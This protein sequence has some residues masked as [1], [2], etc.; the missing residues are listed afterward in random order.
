MRTRDALAAVGGKQAPQG[1]AVRAT[2]AVTG[3]LATRTSR[4]G[5]LVR[6]GV[7]GSALAADPTGFL[8]TP[9]T[10]YASVCGPGSSCSTGWTAF[11]A[12][13]NHGINACPPGS[14]A[15]GWWKS[16]GASLCGGRAR[17]IVDCNATCTCST[18]SGRAGICSPSCW[19]CRCTCGPAG[20]CDQRRVCCNGFRYG[21]CNQQVRQVG[22]VQCRVVSCTPPWK[23]ERCSTSPATD[24]ATRDHNAP[25]LPGAWTALTAHYVALGEHGSELGATI[26]REVAV[27]GGRA[28]RYQHGRMSWS[29]GHG[30]R[31][32]AGAI[33][34]RFGLL[35]AEA[36]LLGFPVAD[37][38]RLGTG[39]ASR[40]QR[41]DIFWHPTTGAHE[42]TGPIL[43]RY[44]QAGRATGALGYPTAGPV[45]PHDG[46]GRAAAF[47]HGR[48]SWHPSLGPARLLGPDLARRY[49]AL[50]AES[51]PLGYPLADETALPAGRFVTLQGGRISW[52][53]T[54]GAWEVRDVLAQAYLG[55]GAETGPLGFPV[56]AEEA[57]AGGRVS[58]FQTGRVAASAATGA[59]WSRGPITERHI[60]LGAEQGQLGFPT[61]D[62]YAPGPGTRRNDYEHGWI[63]YD[64]ATGAVTDSLTPAAD[65]MPPP[66]P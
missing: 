39:R 59:H 17:Y 46:A 23:W 22:A 66:T 35:G 54:T 56:A 57:V 43:T 58:R 28:Q 11:C 55:A 24:N 63:A 12:T 5:F 26:G 41:G 2:E 52:S 25:Q 27:P 45:T 65:P 4:R 50:A 7:L 13:I 42:V 44:N 3:W 60:A 1:V 47:Q 19:S 14:I 51:G 37:P 10:A 33:A 48:I 61:T 30:A 36:G 8:L 15:A 38:D 21:Q 40:F 49:T 29:T 20:Q 6:A 16:D 32:T 62:E 9:G 31:Y 34:G 53:A 18:G 64:E